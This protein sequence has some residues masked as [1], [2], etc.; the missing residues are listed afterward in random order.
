[1]PVRGD[2]L[3]DR[4]MSIEI[5]LAHPLPKQSGAPGPPDGQQIG[6]VPKIT[7][8]SDRYLSLGSGVT[9]IGMG[10]IVTNTGQVF[11][12]RRC[13]D[14]ACNL[15][16]VRKTQPLGSPHCKLRMMP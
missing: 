5:K 16:K 13:P 9:T 10:E 1:M 15:S 14:P 8:K 12:G 2:G 7:Y 3:T 6:G 11:R 4:R